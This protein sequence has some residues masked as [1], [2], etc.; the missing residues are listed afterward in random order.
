[1]AA[2]DVYKR[3]VQNKMHYAVHGGKAAEVIMARADH[4]KEHMGLT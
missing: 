1:M 2:V 3:Q 4:T